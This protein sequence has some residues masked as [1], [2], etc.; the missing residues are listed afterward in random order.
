M[1]GI[2][3][4]TEKIQESCKFEKFYVVKE[5]RE[6]EAEEATTPGSETI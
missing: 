3:G 5:M 6:G 1:R 2:G 4:V